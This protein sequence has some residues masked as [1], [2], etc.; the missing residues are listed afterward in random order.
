MM[1]QGR[2]CVVVGSAPLQTRVTVNATDYVV[3]VN[4]G[5]ASCPIVD[6][7]VLNARSQQDAATCGSKAW[8]HRAMLEQGRGRRVE[9]L[10]LASKG[11]G[12]VF[13]AQHRLSGLRVSARRVRAIE[14]D[15]RREM[16]T[17]AGARDGSMKEHALSLGLFAACWCFLEGAETVR[18][19]GFSWAGGY[20]YLPDTPI[21][22]RGHAAGDKQALGRLAARYPERL[23]HQLTK[24]PAMAKPTSRPL[25]DAAANVRKQVAKNATTP[26]AERAKKVKQDKDAKAA[27]AAAPRRRARMVRATAMTFYAL[28]RRKPGEVFPLRD[29]AD[30]RESCMEDVAPGTAPTPAAPGRPSGAPPPLAPNGADV[31]DGEQ[32]DKGD[33]PLGV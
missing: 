11:A 9:M 1:L 27:A 6:A 16:E 19:E 33:N 24:E 8:L 14:N 21:P 7:W 15:E 23:I 12:A 26:A 25:R 29:P 13:T 30:F 17:Q 20:A 22:V 18:L 4:G 10:V 31:V 5:I 32:D 3:A 28:K 2:H